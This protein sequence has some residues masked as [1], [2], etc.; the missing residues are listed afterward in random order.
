MTRVHPPTECTDEKALTKVITD[1][2]I[3][4]SVSWYERNWE[5]I[6]NRL[7]VSLTIEGVT[8]TQKWQEIFDYQTLPAYRAGQLK[9]LA[10]PYVYL[11]LRRLFKGIRERAGPQ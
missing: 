8:Y 6:S 3:A 9:G 7:G 5:H 1:G 11:S 2:D 4:N 10:V